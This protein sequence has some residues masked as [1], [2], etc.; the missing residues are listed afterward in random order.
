MLTF[1]GLP[2]VIIYH[3]YPAMNKHVHTTTNARAI[4]HLVVPEELPRAD[5]DN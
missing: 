4:E 1:W 2:V 3:T 5:N